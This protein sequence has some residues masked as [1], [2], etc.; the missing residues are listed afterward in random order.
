MRTHHQIHKSK[1][2]VALL[3]KTTPPIYLIQ[4]PKGK[5]LLQMTP[6]PEM[7]SMNTLHECSKAHEV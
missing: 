7:P 6:I 4:T 2:M 5:R 3:A 1:E